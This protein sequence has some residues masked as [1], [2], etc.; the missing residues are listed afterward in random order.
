MAVCVNAPRVRSAL[1]V[2]A[3]MTRLTRLCRTVGVGLA[4]GVATLS[5]TQVANAAP[6]LPA[7]PTGNEQFLAGHAKGVQ[8]YI[9]KAVPVGSTTFKWVFDQPRAT[10]NADNGQVISHFKSPT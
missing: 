9:C 5:M 2:D 7:P 6:T 1:G 4:V 3:G 10:V 8:I